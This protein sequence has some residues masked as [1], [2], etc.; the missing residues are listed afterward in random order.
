MKIATLNV[1]TP[2]LYSLAHIKHDIYCLVNLPEGHYWAHWKYAMRPK[3]DNIHEV[4]YED[5]NADDYDVLI[6]QAPEHLKPPFTEVKM[7]KIFV[8]HG[9]PDV[10]DKP[11]IIDDPSFTIVFNEERNMQL[12]RLNPNMR[13]VAIENA[14]PDD[15]YPWTGTKKCVLAIVRYFAQRGSVCGFNLWQTLT[16][17]LP[18]KVLGD[19]NQELSE[20]VK[21]SK[22]FDELRQE[23]SLNRVY[24]HTTEA[25]A[26]MALREALMAG[27]PVV[28]C[29][30]DIPFENEV[31][32]FK[33]SNMRQLRHYLELCLTDLEVARRVGQAGRRKALELFNINTFAEKWEKLL[34]EVK[35]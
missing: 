5:F 9:L 16:K 11:F 23:Y 1:H 17:G 26:C 22:D 10:P 13:G 2:Y 19:G 21:D 24:F 8:Q 33:S 35:G 20:S 7:P 34:E 4:N 30:E 31:E 12:W 32:I 29:L 28:T 18:R 15:F 14:V 25:Y 3:P 27:M 6:L